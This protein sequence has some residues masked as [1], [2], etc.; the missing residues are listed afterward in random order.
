[1]SSYALPT[2]SL[3]SLIQSLYLHAS[4][5]S[6]ASCLFDLATLS[7]IAAPSLSIY[8]H[9]CRNMP[10]NVSLLIWIHHLVKQSRWLWFSLSFY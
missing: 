3:C 10:F 4:S 2:S 5:I 9:L 7:V 1:M 8:L 6:S